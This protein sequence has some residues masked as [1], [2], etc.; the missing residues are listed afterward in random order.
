[1]RVSKFRRP[2]FFTTFWLMSSYDLHFPKDRYAE[3]EKALLAA[4]DVCYSKYRQ[5]ERSSDKNVRAAAGAHRTQRDRY[6]GA[7]SDLKKERA[8]QEAVYKFTTGK[9]GRLDR[10]KAHWFAHVGTVKAATFVSS[11]IEHCI[12]PRCLLSPMDADYCSRLIK[13]LHERGTPGFHTLMCYNQVIW[14]AI[15]THCN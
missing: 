9:D 13:V 4:A 14:H 11:L 7:V 5:A 1:M 3:T 8:A 12:Q 6:L 10:E 15:I 2:G